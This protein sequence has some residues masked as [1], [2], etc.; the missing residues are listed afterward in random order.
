MEYSPLDLH[1]AQAGDY[2]IGKLLQAKQ[3]TRK[4]SVE[5]STGESLEYHRLLQQWDQLLI[6][7]GLL[8]HVF[9]PTSA[10][11]DIEQITYCLCPTVFWK[12]HWV[13]R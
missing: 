5:N 3:D 10:G 4:P 8:W 12:N 1:R 7:D 2:N 13:V 6:Q 11:R 9:A